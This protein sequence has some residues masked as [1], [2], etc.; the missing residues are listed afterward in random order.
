M[1]IKRI[2]LFCLLVAG[3][4]QLS[5][6]RK[7]IAIDVDNLNPI[8]GATVQSNVGTCITDSTGRFALPDTCKMMFLTHINYE[9]RLVKLAEVR[10]TVYLI[11]K[12]FNLHELVVFGVGRQDDK[13]EE[14]NKRLRLQE[15]DVQMLSAN[16]NQGLNVLGLLKYLIP[17]KWLKDNKADRKKRLEEILDDY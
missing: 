10:D 6:Q 14:L 8:V 5:A 11:S 4:L 2:F 13:M 7:F 15:K 3:C 12:D 9:N 16:P 1:D 17:R